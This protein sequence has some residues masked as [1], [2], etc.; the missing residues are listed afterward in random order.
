VFKELELRDRLGKVKKNLA[1]KTFF[2]RIF[3]EKILEVRS[4]FILERF[5][6]GVD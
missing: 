6:V 2:Q 5:E 4:F 1:R 3:L